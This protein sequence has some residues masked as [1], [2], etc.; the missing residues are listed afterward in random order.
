SNPNPTTDSNGIATTNYTLSTRP[1]VF[2][3]KAASIGYAGTTFTETAVRGGATDLAIASGNSQKGFVASQLPL[4]LKV[5]V[6][7]E[8]N[9]GVSGVVVTFSDG[10]VGGTFSSPTATT[11]GSGFASTFYTTPTLA[12]PID[13]PASATA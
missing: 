7:D 4:P 3:I 8:K 11:D 13:I 9:N 6:K 1:G 5:K 2:T 12:A 10:G